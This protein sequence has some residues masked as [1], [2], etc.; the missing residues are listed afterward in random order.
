MTEHNNIIDATMD[1]KF[2]LHTDVGAP[3]YRL[4][5]MDP[6][7]PEKEHWKEIIP[8]QEMLLRECAMSGGKLVASYLDK[9]NTRIKIFDADGSNGKNIEL[10]DRTGSAGGFSAKKEDTYCFY[11]FSSFTYP[12]VI[13]K[14][15]FTTGESAEFSRLKLKFSPEDFESKQV[16]Y[17]S[18][19]GTQVPMFIVH[20]RN[21][22][23]R[24]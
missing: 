22:P 18:K 2:L 24:K 10:P 19:D 4:V 16:M 3:T 7:K 9:G 6:S 14:Y 17:T 23:Q 20:K 12:G 5:E 11:S 15:D 13:Y 8:A 1:G 21:R